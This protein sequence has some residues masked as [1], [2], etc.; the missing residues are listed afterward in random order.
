MSMSHIC[1]ANGDYDMA[2]E[3]YR[4]VIKK[5]RDN[6]YYLSCKKDL[7]N[8][9]YEK[10]VAGGD[11]STSEL[12]DLEQTFLTTLDEF[13]RNGNVA[14]MMMN[15]AELYTFYMHNTQ[16]GIDLLYEVLELPGI[17]RKDLALAK[18]Q[19]ADALLFTG[20]VWET[21]LLYSQA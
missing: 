2:I 18:V 16:K 4:Y 9:L 7:V 19:L 21:T 3:G 1:R 15:L 20:E 14:Q 6:Y 5:G 12:E 10:A 13:G 8:T 11:Y 17:D